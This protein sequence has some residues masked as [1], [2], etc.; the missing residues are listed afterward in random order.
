MC[1]GARCS[2]SRVVSVFGV[3]LA[4]LVLTTAEAHAQSVTLSIRRFIDATG[5]VTSS[6]AGISCTTAK[7]NPVGQCSA[8]FPVGTVVTLT[9]VPGEQ[10]TFEGWTGGVCVEPGTCQDAPLCAGTG[11]C[12]VTLTQDFEVWAHFVATRYPVTIVATGNGSGNIHETPGETVG[13]PPLA[14]VIRKGQT[15]TSLGSTCTT[16]VAYNSVVVL[17]FETS[18]DATNRLQYSSECPDQDGGGT[19]NARITGPTTITATIV[20][21]EFRVKSAGGTGTGTVTSDVGT[22]CVVTSAGVSGVCGRIYDDGTPSLVTLVATPAEGSRFVGWSGACTSDPCTVFAAHPPNVPEAVALFEALPE[23]TVKLVV[24]GIAG[25]GRGRVTSSPAGIDCDFSDPAKTIG[26][27]TCLA[28]FRFGTTVQLTATPRDGTKVL[29]FTGD[30]ASQA[31]TCTVIMYHDRSA[32]VQLDPARFPVTIVASGNGSGRVVGTVPDGTGKIDC[33]VT[34]GLATG[35]GCTALYPFG[36]T[37][38]ILG[39]S[40]EN[41]RFVGFSVPPCTVATSCS[42]TVTGP[43]SITATFQLVDGSPIAL[44]VVG[45]GT[46]RGIVTAAPGSTQCSFNGVLPDNS[47]TITYAQPTQVTLTA[48]PQFGSTFG[49]WTGD[50]CSGTDLTCTFI[51]SAATAVSVNFISPHSAH[52]LGLAL[53]GGATLS[54]NDRAGL[55]RLGNQNGVYDLGDLLAY[56]DRT[57]QKL[58]ATEAAA[59]MAVPTAPSTARTTRRVP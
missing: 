51:L 1:C 57:G 53:I 14:C 40:E 20:A 39:A 47:C 13:T 56:L 35:T 9:A 16:T 17:S 25:F 3:A 31:T 46:G 44:T 12:Q 23:N 59:V 7:F 54:P 27:G 48:S 50:M 2:S 22:N 15:Q 21:A 8:T 10:N 52:D 36:S 26:T 45:V 34:S 32:T 30:C 6:P 58:T 28:I 33:T 29:G 19:C 24:N 43:L 49:G 55:D 11:T 18:T 42:A 38:F 41:T 37:L 4:V 5:T